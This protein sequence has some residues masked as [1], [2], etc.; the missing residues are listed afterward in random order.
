MSQDGARGASSQPGPVS[1]DEHERIVMEVMQQRD[2]A[3]EVADALATKVAAGRWIGE[4]SSENNPWQNALDLPDAALTEAQH[5]RAVEALDRLFRRAPLPGD[6]SAYR[7]FVTVVR[8]LHY[9]AG[10]Y[11]E[12][13]GGPFDPSAS[14]DGAANSSWCATRHQRAC[15]SDCRSSASSD[16]RASTS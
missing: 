13:L 3:Y 6:D 2:L 12:S 7:E 8:A 9:A 14:G 4:H 1:Y 5:G 10:K 15:G 16:S 11:D